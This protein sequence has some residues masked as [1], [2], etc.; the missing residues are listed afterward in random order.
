MYI[1]REIK[2][3]RTFGERFR[4]CLKLAEITFIFADNVPILCSSCD[5]KQV[6][7][8]VKLMDKTKTQ[9][10]SV[11]FQRG[12]TRTSKR[13]PSKPVLVYHSPLYIRSSYQLLYTVSRCINRNY[14]AILATLQI[15]SYVHS[16]NSS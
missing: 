6:I 14:S 3:N 12:L 8:L 11:P 13:T 2:K 9:M 10:I 16:R 1:V 5:V 4:S 7:T 15:T